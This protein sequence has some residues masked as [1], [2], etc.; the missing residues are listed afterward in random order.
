MNHQSISCLSSLTALA[1]AM[2]PVAVLAQQSTDSRVAD[3]VQGGK[4]RAGIGVVAPHWAVKD[5]A[6]GELRGVAVDVGRALAT[7]LGIAFAPVEYP[8]PPL[9]LG[10]LKT[11]AWDVGFLSVD[12]A[13]ADLVDFSTAYLEIDATYVLPAGSSIQRIADADRPNLRIAVTRNSAEW[14]VLKGMVKQAKLEI[15]ETVNDGFELLR[16]GNA[17]A[18]AIPRPT[19]LLVSGR[20]PGSRVLEDRFFTAMGAIA[21]PKGQSAHLAYISEFVEQAK[22][23]GLIQQAIE[24]NSVRGV[25]ALP[26]GSQK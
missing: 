2:L 11:G 21:V 6:T 24:R 14:N 18:L 7:H 15:V 9:V 25:R 16:T 4:L 1:L 23:S 17:E 13:R 22:A 20:L 5:P 26:P 8:G 12:P 3:L 19:A 10:G